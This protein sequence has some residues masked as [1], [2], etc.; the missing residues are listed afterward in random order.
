MSLIVLTTYMKRAIK[1]KFYDKQSKRLMD[2]KSISWEYGI[3]VC[4][5]AGESLSSFFEDGDLLQYTGRKDK[6]IV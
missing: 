6:Y 2:V 5:F 4:V 3:V 1:F